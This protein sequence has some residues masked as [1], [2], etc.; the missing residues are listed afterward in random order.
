MNVGVKLWSFL[1]TLTAHAVDYW[2]GELPVVAFYESVR[3]SGDMTAT[4]LSFL[5]Y[6]RWL[7]ATALAEFH[8]PQ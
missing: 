1:S 7:P 4:C 8:G 6:R 2:G 3:L 5:S